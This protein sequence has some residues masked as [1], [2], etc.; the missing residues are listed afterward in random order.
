MGGGESAVGR[1]GEGRVGVTICAWGRALQWLVCGEG[2]RE[3]RAVCGAG[4][5]SKEGFRL[6]PIKIRR[7][8]LL[9]FCEAQFSWP[10]R[11]FAAR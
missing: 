10:L 2:R 4:V 9:P 5:G 1:G 11:P 8:N 3:G 7:T 6:S